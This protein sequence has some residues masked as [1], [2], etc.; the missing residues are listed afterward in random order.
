[1]AAQKCRVCRCVAH[2]IW[3]GLWIALFRH[4]LRHEMHRT[5]GRSS[6]MC[7]AG[8]EQTVDTLNQNR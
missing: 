6:D 2:L 4:Q 7:L 1:M 3:G 8:A 5:F